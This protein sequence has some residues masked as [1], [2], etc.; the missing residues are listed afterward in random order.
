MPIQRQ[1]LFAIRN[2][3]QAALKVVEDKHHI[4]FG[5]LGRI[6]YSESSIRCKLEGFANVDGDYDATV[7]VNRIKFD[8]DCARC[9][10]SSDAFGENF[11][12]DGELYQVY[13]VLPKGKKNKVSAVRLSDNS[14]FRFPLSLVPSRFRA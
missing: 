6:V 14:R 9:G 3:I 4:K 13:G 11:E 7:N 8:A 10:V 2:D 5:E 12:Y 1:D